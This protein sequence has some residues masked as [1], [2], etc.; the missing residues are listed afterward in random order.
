MDIFRFGPALDGPGTTR[1]AFFEV[2]G[3]PRVFYQIGDGICI[4]KG[5]VGDGKNSVW[6]EPAC[7]D[8]KSTFLTTSHILEQLWATFGHPWVS[9]GAPMSRKVGPLGDSGRPGDHFSEVQ[10]K[11]K[12]KVKERVAGRTCFVPY[13]H[14]ISIGLGL[15]GQVNTPSTPHRAF[16]ARWR[17]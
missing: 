2:F 16:G 1:G 6:I 12:K 15:K 14:P 8:R 5:P 9:I 10:K 17:I 13:N 11:S 4:K 3:R 7:A